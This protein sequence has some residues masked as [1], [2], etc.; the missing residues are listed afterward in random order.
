MYLWTGC[1]VLLWNKP[2]KSRWNQSVQLCTKT[3]LE[4][5]V[6]FGPENMSQYVANLDWDVSVIQIMSCDKLHYQV[7]QPFFLARHR[8]FLA[9]H[10]C[11]VTS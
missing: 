11:L 9:R 3:R 5:S 7:V 2:I 4:I 6:D 10:M 8:C 1:E